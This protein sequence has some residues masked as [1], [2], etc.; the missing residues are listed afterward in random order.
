MVVVV[1]IEKLNKMKLDVKL[2]VIVFDKNNK[3]LFLYYTQSVRTKYLRSLES[4]EQV[5]WIIDKE[6]FNIF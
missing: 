5:L 1:E 6:I 2:D 4:L 3:C